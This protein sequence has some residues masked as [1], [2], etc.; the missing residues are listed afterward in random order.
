MFLFAAL[1]YFVWLGYGGAIRPLPRYFLFLAVVAVIPIS[2]LMQR[3]RFP[4][5]AMLAVAGLVAANY[6]ALTVENIHPRFAANQVA[7]LADTAD[8]PIVTDPETASR[9]R[10]IARF[11]R[12]ANQ[13]LITTRG[14]AVHGRVDRG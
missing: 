8:Q 4:G 3:T 12:S 10:Q 5:S 11:R 14:A 6:L 13:G 9:A 1:V 7:L 2:L